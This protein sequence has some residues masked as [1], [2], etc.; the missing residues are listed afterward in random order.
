MEKFTLEQIEQFLNIEKE[1]V[2]S[3]DY[4]RGS[5]NGFLGNDEDADTSL[6]LFTTM[7]I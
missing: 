2:G 6:S 4:I 7:F 1:T 3:A 5:K